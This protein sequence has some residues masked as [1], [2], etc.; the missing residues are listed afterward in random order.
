MQVSCFADRARDERRG[1]GRID[2]AGERANHACRSP[3]CARISVDRAVD[4]RFHLPRR[5]RCRRFRAGSCRGSLRPLLGVH[6]FGMKLHAV[7]LAARRSPIAATLQRGVDASA[8]ETRRAVERPNRRATSTHA[9]VGNVVEQRRPARRLSASPARTRRGRAV[10]SSRAERRAR[11]AAS[12]SRCPA[13]VRRCVEDRAD[14]SR[15]RPAPA[16][17]PDRRTE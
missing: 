14:P 3:T 7:D 10:T 1:N 13:A 16:C 2:A 9:I 17:S 4:E 5:P 12:R 8:H 15:A 6:D 11:S